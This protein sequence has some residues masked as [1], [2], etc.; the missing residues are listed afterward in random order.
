M[1]SLRMFTTQRPA[2]KTLRKSMLTERKQTKP[3]I[4]EVR[5]S[6]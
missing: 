2:V 3:D 1:Q 5:V 6:K 4:K